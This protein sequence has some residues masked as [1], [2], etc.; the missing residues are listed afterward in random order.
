MPIKCH[1]RIADRLVVFV[2]EG[3]VSDDEFL[4]TYT[5]CHEDPRFDRAFNVLVD[6]RRTESDVRSSSVLRAFAD[7]RHRW[8]GD[9]QVHA[10]VAVIA[11]QDLSFGLARMYEIY[12]ETV[13]V[14]FVV[15]RAADAALAWLG[16]PE[17]LLTCPHP[18]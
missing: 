10:K 4:S 2:H 13:P 8:F 1:Y 18:G 14:D 5:A 3:V 9:K 15:F 12:S 7:F 6:L 11:P 16:A 17:D